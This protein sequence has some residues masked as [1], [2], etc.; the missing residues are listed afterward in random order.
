MSKTSQLAA[1]NVLQ[2]TYSNTKGNSS[3]GS[4]PFLL[5]KIIGSEVIGGF[6]NLP[7]NILYQGLVGLEGNYLVLS[8]F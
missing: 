5:F 4:M 8:I 1:S 3:N 7:T 2:M 6:L